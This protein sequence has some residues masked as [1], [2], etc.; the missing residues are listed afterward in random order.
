MMSSWTAFSQIT[1]ISKEQ[2]IEIVSTLEAYPIVL[3]QVKIQSDIIFNYEKIVKDNE[4]QL[5]LCDEETNKLQEVISN[6][7][8]IIDNLN[9]QL[10]SAKK[11]GWEIPTLVGMLLGILFT[12]IF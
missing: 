11:E 3:Q 4:R 1:G 2:K 7:K 10:K 6:D 8:K 12:N 5:I 9:L